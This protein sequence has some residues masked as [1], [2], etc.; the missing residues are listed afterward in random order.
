MKGTNTANLHTPS[1]HSLS[2]RMKET[3]A[4]VLGLPR[5]IL[6]QRSPSASPY[7][8]HFI[9]VTS[10]LYSTLYNIRIRRPRSVQKPQQ[11][12]VPQLIS[13]CLRPRQIPPGRLAL[14]APEGLQY[15]PALRATQGYRPT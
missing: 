15:R 1:T 8:Q 5:K 11:I 13:H 6:H 7:I 2:C 12:K 14:T 9:L 10:P 4:A 3:N